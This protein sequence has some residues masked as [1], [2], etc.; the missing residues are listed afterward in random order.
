MSIRT[1]ITRQLNANR[2]R[3][4]VS[5]NGRERETD[6][7]SM[8]ML[9]GN[10][11]SYLESLQ[12]TKLPAEWRA[13]DPLANH[14]WVFAA[15]AAIART[16]GQA[17]FTV[18][19]KQREPNTK[20]KFGKQRRNVAMFTEGL[21]GIQRAWKLI[22]AKDTSVE[23]DHPIVDLLRNPNPY[24]QGS[25]LIQLT[26]LWLSIRGECFWVMT[27]DDGIPTSINGSKLPTRLWPVGPDAF[28]AIRENHFAG[29][30][31]GWSFTLPNWMP[32]AGSVSKKI[33]LDLDEVIQFKT[34]NPSDPTRGLS[35]ITAV[36]QGIQTDLKAKTYNE[37]IL[38]NQGKP[39]GVLTTDRMMTKEERDEVLGYW[40]DRHEGPENAARVAM[41]FGG[42]KWQQIAL[43][44]QDMEFLKSS[45]W[46]R[47]E[48]LAVIGTP[49]SVLG[50]PNKLNYATQ[51]GQ[52]RNFWDKTVL[53]YY[54]LIE[55]TIDK[56]LFFTSPDDI[57]GIFN[58]NNI[59]AMRV[60]I[61]EKIKM[62]NE[63][64]GNNLHT[65]PKVAYIVVGLE[66][67]EYE[68]DD[69]SLVGALTTPLEFALE[70]DPE[71]IALPALKPK[72]DKGLFELEELEDKV[73][74]ASGGKRHR[75]YIKIQSKLERKYIKF[76]R[77]WVIGEKSRFMKR[78]D[79]EIKKARQ[80]KAFNLGF[81]LGKLF[82]SG[83]LLKGKILGITLSAA[84]AAHKFDLL[85]I[86]GFELIPGLIGA[87][88]KR[89][90]DIVI[91]S[92]PKT[93]RE[94]LRRKLVEGLKK[95]VSFNKLRLAVLDVFNKTQSTAH[96]TTVARTETGGIMNDV[97]NQEFIEA[98]IKKGEW[99]NAG[100]I[101]VRE[102]HVVFGK[103]GVHKL[104][105]NYASLVS[106]T[107]TLE[108]P[109]DSRASAKQV[110]ACRC[111]L[112]AIK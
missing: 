106:D 96:A 7:V 58:V 72:P 26:L 110:V 105:F 9:L 54:R 88:V 107:G 46:N 48:I 61:A 32:G 49:P 19:R 2:S 1:S 13:R 5:K 97:R 82:K 92:V 87:A 14:P 43:S 91:K 6:D 70:P 81:V 108:F 63:M 4:I 100:D 40:K 104:G 109:L 60:G 3:N 24:Q 101:H 29:Q 67:P 41:L 83:K 36:A 94:S 86:P 12:N 25:Q 31:I 53:P 45:E 79:S 56:A 84:E 16:A 77:S 27:D 23:V 102:D 78:F 42:L 75:Q 30:V 11:S 37:R 47:E 68:G 73:S 52:D 74:K 33:P 28:E 39:G 18:F 99:S 20:P 22:N 93:L 103:S 89:R 71:P 10:I 59:E 21:S 57:F 95:G 98:G 62:A 112:L 51:L 85:D 80:V 111:L 76:F 44:P 64:C 90:M 65:P 66:V 35:P 38:D 8:K 17:P 50:L 55:T 69:T 15:A 34:A